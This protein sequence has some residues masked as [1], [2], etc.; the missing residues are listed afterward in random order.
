MYINVVGAQGIHSLLKVTDHEMS[1][2]D[3]DYQP[4]RI[5]FP[6][7]SEQKLPDW[8][9]KLPNPLPNLFQE[10]YDAFSGGHYALATMGI[11]AI[12][13]RLLK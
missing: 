3:P 4:R 9:W 6:K 12:I 7:P 8:Y 2:D 5:I 13:D 1:Y 10:T 11:R